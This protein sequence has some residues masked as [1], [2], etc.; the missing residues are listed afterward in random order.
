MYVL[1]DAT[2]PE[3]YGGLPKNPTVAIVVNYG[4]VR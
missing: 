1:H 2:K 4:R 3:L